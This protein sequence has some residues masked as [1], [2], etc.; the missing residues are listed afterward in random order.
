M[1]FEGRK[2]DLP[3]NAELLFLTHCRFVELESL[4]FTVA[5][6]GDRCSYVIC[7]RDRADA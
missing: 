2:D 6:H 7:G 3:L 5:D 4:Q 1:G